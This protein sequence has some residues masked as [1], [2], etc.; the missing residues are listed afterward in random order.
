MYG[1]KI[2][3]DDSLCN[4]LDCYYP[5]KINK[6]AK[7]LRDLG[8]PLNFC[9]AALILSS[10]NIYRAAEYLLNNMIKYDVDNE[11]FFLN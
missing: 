10:F 5:K 3:K 9:K 7:R 4:R 8:F 6:S 11:C 2:K 1:I